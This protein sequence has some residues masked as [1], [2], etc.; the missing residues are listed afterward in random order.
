MKKQSLY[1]R[2]AVLLCCSLAAA[3][4]SACGGTESNAKKQEPSDDIAHDSQPETPSSSEALALPHAVYPLMAPYPNDTEFFYEDGTFNDTA[5]DQAYDAWDNSRRA[6]RE[7]PE[8]YQE[9]FS[10]FF[11]SSLPVFLSGDSKENHI[12]SPLNVYMAL[13]MLA[14]I[15]DGNS[16]R[17]IL[18]TLGASDIDTLRMQ[19]KAVWN[20]NYCRDGAVTSVLASSL[21][22]SNQIAFRPE[23]L[24]SLADIYYASSYQGTMGSDELNG[25][26]QNWLDEQ[27][28][29]LLAEQAKQVKLDADTV[30]ALAT[31]VFYQARWADSFSKSET[32]PG[33]FHTPDGDT[34]CDF[35]HQSGPRNYYWGEHFAAV[36]Q[37]MNAGGGS[38]WFFLPDEGTDVSDLLTDGEIL[39]LLSADSGQ[40]KAPSE[41]QSYLIVNLS[42][43]KFDAVSQ[44]DLADGLKALGITDVFDTERSDFSPLTES[45]APLFVSSA[46][47]AA[48]VTI[49]EDGCTATAFTVIA[50]A[51]TA[52]PPDEEVD[53][54][55][56]RPFLFVLTGMD[57]LPLFAGIINHP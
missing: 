56:D 37:Y 1:Q 15:T 29:G 18:N 40:S 45:S 10:S 38:M 47:H 3:V 23:T 25:E 32:A 13:G 48:R 39:S 5:F 52:M 19:A 33:T 4:L 44:L 50:V 31:T 42:V 41:N 55:L 30:I 34:E 17:Q 12:Y 36:S 2:T 11:A 14:E 16:R 43:P 21:W 53:F 26:L 51:G 24:S 57:G 7:Q 35:M 49:D 9:G 6:Q 46:Q 8:G 20:A 27:T 28:G 54:I 22:L